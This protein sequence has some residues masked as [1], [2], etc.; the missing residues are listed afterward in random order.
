[1]L[2]TNAL[3][4]TSYKPTSPFEKTV[5]L[6]LPS[7]CRTVRTP[8][9]AGLAVKVRSLTSFSTIVFDK[10]ITIKLVANKK[11]KKILGV[12]C[13]GFGDA[14]KRVNV[15]TTALL[16]G[17]TLDEFVNTDLTYTPTISTSIDP[18]LTA[19]QILLDRLSK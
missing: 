1:M 11:S 18:I 5:M 9:N 16:K 6:L 7:T 4:L 15:V 2:L 17:Y 19:A 14:D 12:Q 3:T 8:V 10:S 13:V